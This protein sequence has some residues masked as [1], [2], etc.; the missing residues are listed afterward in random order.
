M[1]STIDQL[2]FWIN[3]MPEEFRQ[4]SEIEISQRPAPQKWSKKEILGHLCDSAIN[5]LER[6]IKIQYEKEPLVL[7]P[8]DQVHWVKIQDYQ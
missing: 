4:M 6:F 3:K 7:T 2:Y 8:Y 5:N 1:Q